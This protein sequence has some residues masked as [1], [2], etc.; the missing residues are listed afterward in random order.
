VVALRVRILGPLE[1]EGYDPGTLGSRKQRSLLRALALGRGAPVSVDR[2]AECLWP[3]R[4]PARPADQVGVL[5]SRLRSVLGG[6]RV[7]RGDAGYALAADWID[8]AA[9]YQLTAEAE[10][11]LAD[12][13]TAA[14][15]TAA[16]AGL[17]LVRGP[18]LADEPDA[19]WADEAR[20]SVDRILAGL[21]LVAAK[22]SLATGDPFSAASA[23]QAV[24]DQDPYD[25][26]ALRLLMTAHARA[27]RPGTALAVYA[28]TRAALLNDLGASPCEL[29][30]AL[31]LAI[32]R[33]EMAADPAP[34][35]PRV[36]AGAGLPGRDQQWQSLDRALSQAH[37]R[38]GLIVIEGE[39][40]MG[41]TK[42]LEAWSESVSSEAVVLWGRCEPVGFSLPFQAVLD[43]L[44]RHLARVDELEAEDLR[45]VAGPV[46]GPLLPGHS[47]PATVPDP[48]TAQA[49][50]FA[51]ALRVCCRAARTGV[52]VL[53]LDDVHLADAATVAWLGF[54]AR[55]PASGS[56]LIAVARR[57]GHLWSLTGAT[58]ITVGP[59][60]LA[61]ATEIVGSVRA[62]VLWERSRGNP[63]FL[64]ELAGFDGDELPASI[65]EAVA[66]R[67]AQLGAAEQTLRTAA[68]LGPEVDLDLL[69]GVLQ[70]SAV[71]LLGDLEEGQRQMIL[72]ER[73]TTFVFRHELLREALVAGTGASRRALAHREGARLLAGRPHH[74][75]L[76]IAIHARQ[77]GNLELAAGALVEA[78]SVASS[79]FDHAEAQ[80]LLDDSL[81]LYP[82][83]AGYLARG[84]VC[85]TTENFARASADAQRALAMGAGAQALELA[86]WSAYYQRD[87]GTA[88]ALCNQARAALG[89]GD[90]QLKL[91]VLALA[92]RIA[93]ADGDLHI[94]QENLES[95]LEASSA[96]RPGVAG[97]W[98]GWLMA[99]RGEHERAENLAKWAE[100]DGSLALHPFGAAHRALLASYSS[101]LGGR[102]AQALSLLDVVDLEVDLQHLDH[103]VGRTA[104]Y[105]AWLLRNLLFD[106]EADEL[107]LA[108]AEIAK[109]RGLR[110]PQAQSALDLADAHLRRGELGGCAAALDLAQS[111]GTGYA[112]GWK[113]QLRGQLLA[114]RLALV[115]HRPEEAEYKAGAVAV[116]AS[117]IGVPRYVTIARVLEARARSAT[118]HRVEGRSLEQMLDDLCRFAAPE[119]WWTTAE[120][121]RD[122]GADRLW[123]VAEQRAGSIAA[124]AGPRAEE[125]RL[126]AGKWLD[127]M[128]SSRRSG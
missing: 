56:L 123:R 109:A 96:D 70:T 113:A 79:R 97:V 35:L 14:A 103:F 120:L 39:A 49:A 18:L 105:R 115:D 86:S 63:L 9:L 7:T 75:P 67:C 128:R 8:L 46:L 29:T 17:A 114:A 32:L 4:L 82:L 83:A 58:H 52:A 59:L 102:I 5:V 13:Q 42:L 90:N 112:F 62:P 53:V 31:H 104:N 80:R 1:V 26:H 2:L 116:D 111:L 126:H 73:G 101:A 108:A 38:V 99:D 68:V 44:C 69:A 54:V 72:E 10:R 66:A 41:K 85:L 12:E 71:T 84:R 19:A 92:G 118:G 3:R 25:E 77:G 23:A 107:N 22:A 47:G 45:A 100:R 119:A 60:D 27:G 93:H 21:R 50:V 89:E 94:A 87:F 43:A 74:D 124:G 106:S 20:I 88:R 57:P 33:D 51:G 81:D 121:A 55:Q 117:R 76:A 95:A 37:G 122:L 61:A 91:S 30:E 36:G 127:K 78:A 11:R 28:R 65:L 125:F 24:L 64:V 34:S 98:L 6:Q 110:E 48:L 16:M 15:A 40:G